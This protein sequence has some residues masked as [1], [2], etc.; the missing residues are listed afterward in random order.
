[1]AG[2]HRTEQRIA[3]CVNAERKQLIGVLSH[4]VRNRLDILTNLIAAR[5]VE[6]TRKETAEDERASEAAPATAL[7]SKAL[8]HQSVLMQNSARAARLRAARLRAVGQNPRLAPS[9]GTSDWVVAGA[10]LLP[11][12]NRH[13]NPGP[14]CRHVGG[15]RPA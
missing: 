5:S 2:A 15:S 7:T 8:V 9:V 10:D 6:P 12:P 4:E 11:N 1:V 14:V 13:P 3:A